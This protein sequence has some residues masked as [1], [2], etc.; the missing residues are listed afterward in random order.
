MDALR[1]RS[2]ASFR[3]LLSAVIAS[4]AKRVEAEAQALAEEFYKE[5]A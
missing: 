1:E 2:G 4:E 3:D 5:S